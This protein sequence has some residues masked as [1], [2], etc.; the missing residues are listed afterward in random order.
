M[1]R[2]QRRHAKDT[3]RRLVAGMKRQAG[4]DTGSVELRGGPMDGW[5]VKADAPAL[6]PDWRAKALEGVARQ[7]HEKTRR[8]GALHG[9]DPATMP[10]WDQLADGDRSKY[11]GMAR[12]AHGGGRYVRVDD[13]ERRFA[14]W[15]A[16]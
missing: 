10:T 12:D 8:I 16:E 14:D 9:V 6:E 3:A 4:K 2:A 11:I 1:N 5:I 15:R 13:G 7:A